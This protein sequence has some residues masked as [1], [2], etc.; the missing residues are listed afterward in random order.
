MNKVSCYALRDGKNLLELINRLPF[1]LANVLKYTFRYQKK[2]TPLQDLNKALN[3]LEYV[4]FEM[5]EMAKYDFFLE[6][7]FE[8]NA[9]NQLFEQACCLLRRGYPDYQ[10][11]EEKCVLKMFIEEAIA[12]E[13]QAIYGI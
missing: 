11:D 9:P 10:F 7:Q 6:V 12:E 2:G 8:K 5:I 1:A 4:D 3:Y 13:E